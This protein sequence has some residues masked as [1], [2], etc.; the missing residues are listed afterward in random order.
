MIKEF[1]KL[2]GFKNISIL[3]LICQTSAGLVSPYISVFLSQKIHA[4]S[5]Q[6][7]LY[8]TMNS[9]FAIGISIFIA[10]LSDKIGKRQIFIALALISAVI[11]YSL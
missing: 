4:T 6:I 5:F 11:G 8:V 1:K 2:F 3:L 10:N 7:G 9:L